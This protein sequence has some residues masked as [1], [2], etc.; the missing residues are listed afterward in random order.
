[1]VGISYF[2]Q[3]EASI[4]ANAVLND[5]KVDANAQLFWDEVVD[6]LVKQGDLDLVVH[7]V[8]SNAI[9]ECDTVEDLNKLEAYLK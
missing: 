7:E 3:A 5:V 1:M 4:I 9:V 6:R 8:P 2:K